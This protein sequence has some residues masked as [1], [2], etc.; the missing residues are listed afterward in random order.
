M[1]QLLTDNV[2]QQVAARLDSKERKLAAIAYVT[3]NAYL[4][5]KR[6]D[7]LIC[8][9]SDS[10]IKSGQ[11][12]AKVLQQLARSGVQ[13]F[14][15]PGLH[16]K[17][18]VSGDCV[19]VGS[20]NLSTLAAERLI[21]AAFVTRRFQA[22]SQVRAFIE[23]LKAISTPIDDAFLKRATRLPVTRR[24]R[25]TTSVRALVTTPTNK[26]WVVSTTP[27]SERVQERERKHEE[28]GE[29]R[30][31]QRIT[32][33]RSDLYWIRF[34]GKLRFRKT[35]SEGDSVIEI[36]SNSRG[37]RCR[38]FQPRP[39]LLRQDKENWTRFWIEDTD[40]PKIFSWRK[41]DAEV[42]SLGLNG[43]TKK[44]TRELTSR[45]TELMGVIWSHNRT[46]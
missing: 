19:V 31:K 22:R 18:L 25:S 5:L 4:R 43:I 33:P 10:S 37:N 28:A 20:S 2:W 21:E 38:V 1:D 3:N 6:G 32:N 39:I 45:E 11:T 40:S 29:R 17:S 36:S 27:L 35:A 14:S 44:T 34:T 24:F 15:C 8:D 9:A 13:I 41:F 42:R 30:A 7:I 23:K 46:L 12:S 26:T 16:A